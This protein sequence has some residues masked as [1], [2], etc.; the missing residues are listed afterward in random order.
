MK[1]E[2]D[3]NIDELLAKARVPAIV[4]PKRGS[5]DAWVAFVPGLPPCICDS[6]EGA[7]R[8]VAP[9]LTWRERKG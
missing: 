9:H 4:G 6:F 7:C 3:V 2:I 1:H 8:I 5:G